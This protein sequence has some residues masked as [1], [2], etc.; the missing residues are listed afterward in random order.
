MPRPTAEQLREM[1]D[2]DPEAGLL[3]W[4]QRRQ[5]RHLGRQP[6]RLTEKG[7][8]RITISGATYRA[9]AL[10]WTMMTGEWP[11]RQVDHKDTYGPKADWGDRW[12]NLRLATSTQN[13]RNRRVRASSKTGHAGVNIDGSVYIAWIQSAP[14]K[15][16]R[17]GRFA[18][19]GAAVAARRAAEAEHYGEFAPVHEAAQ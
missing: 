17:L 7:H 3:F 5:G 8:R 2:Y 14:Y 13:T 6:G 16:L 15:T 19:L 1:L 18:E 11:D 9:T 4:K 12:S 10:I